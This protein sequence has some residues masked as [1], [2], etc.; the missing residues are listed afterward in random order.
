M[1][2]IRL[3]QDLGESPA[4]GDNVRRLFFGKTAIVYEAEVS[5]RFSVWVLSPVLNVLRERRAH[6]A[7]TFPGLKVRVYR[8]KG[9]KNMDKKL[10]FKELI[11]LDTW[12]C[13]SSSAII[14]A[15]R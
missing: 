6:T 10:T 15:G 13:P 11:G 7:S 9:E 14:L 1:P 3:I 12:T 4:G 8:V 2:Y 5:P